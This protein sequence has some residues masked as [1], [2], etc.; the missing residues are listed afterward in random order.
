MSTPASTHPAGPAATRFGSGR[1]VRRVED[2][3]LL[4][5]EGRYVDDLTQDG[6]LYMVFQRSPHAHARIIAINSDAAK[7]MEGVV[8]LYTGADLVAAGV[9]P[10]P[11]PA[12]FK[13]ADGSPGVSAP[14]RPLAHERVRFVGEAVVGVVADSPQR[15]KDVH[16]SAMVA[17]RTR[18]SS[19]ALPVK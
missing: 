18:I 3:K 19:V 16:A 10:M 9:K 11:P 1:E 12:N 7:A 17:A 2:E 4:R 13:R 6:Q 15:A 14:R 5:G 8:A